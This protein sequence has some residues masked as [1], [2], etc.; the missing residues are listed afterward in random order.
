MIASVDAIN[1]CPSVKL[2]RIKKLLRFFARKFTAAT[3]KT[4]HLCLGLIRFIMS[5]TPISFDGEYYEYP[6]GKK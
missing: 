2:S 3:N 5:S 4:I 6:G 1:M